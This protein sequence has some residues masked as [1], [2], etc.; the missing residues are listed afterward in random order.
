M[1]NDSDP[2]AP[3]VELTPWL[4]VLITFVAVFGQLLMR[5]LLLALGASPA[6]AFGIALL[7]SFGGAFAMAAPFIPDPPARSLGLRA[8]PLYAW[9]AVPLLLPTRLLASEVDNV[10]RALGGLPL[11][12]QTSEDVRVAEWVLVELFVLPAVSELFYR[13]ALQPRFT[14]AWG[15]RWGVLA[16]AA[17]VGVASALLFDNLLIAGPTA[18]AALVLGILR[19]CSGSILPGLVLGSLFGAVGLLAIERVFGIPG[20]DDQTAAHTPLR[21]LVP[22]A[23]LVAGG[24]ALCRAASTKLDGPPS[25]DG[26]PS[27]SGQIRS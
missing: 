16:M 14:Q 27:R 24:L 2:D 9:L 19:H 10:L 18:L 22:A 6:A 26:G 4:C 11:L 15:E 20:F 7:V 8:P 17:L 21:W 12:P 23:L 1:R 5:V 3:D 25:R 13:G